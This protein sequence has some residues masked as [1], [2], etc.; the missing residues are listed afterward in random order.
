[1]NLKDM[2]PDKRRE[3]CSKGGKAVAGKD[4]MFSKDREL[5]SRA[6]AL[7]GQ[8]VSKNGRNFKNDRELARRAAVLSNAAQK[9]RR[10]EMK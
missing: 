4:R 2:S 3:V 1:M 6:G 7:G 9:K 10:E 8:L 5:A